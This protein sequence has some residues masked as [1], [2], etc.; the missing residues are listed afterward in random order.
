MALKWYC[1]KCDQTEKIVNG[2]RQDHK[3]KLC[4]RCKT[5]L[6]VLDLQRG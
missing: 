6:I 2:K 1:T 3:K 5:K 4:K